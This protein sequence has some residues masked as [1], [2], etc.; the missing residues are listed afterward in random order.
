MPPSY[1]ITI[2]RFTPSPSSQMNTSYTQAKSKSKSSG[3]PASA[4][5]DCITFLQTLASSLPLH[6]DGI[7]TLSTALAKNTE[8]SNALS[9]SKAALDTATAQHEA[10]LRTVQTANEAAIR[11]R[12]VKLRENEV[13]LKLLRGGLKR[14]ILEQDSREADLVAKVSDAEAA[15]KKRVAEVEA[16]G[17]RRVAKMEV[18]VERARREVDEVKRA[19]Q[20]S[21]GRERAAAAR[22]Q[23]LQDSINGLN[24]VVR[25]KEAEVL[26]VV[27]REKERERELGVVSVDVESFGAGLAG[28]ADRMQALVQEHI[29]DRGLPADP[30][31]LTQRQEHTYPDLRNALAQSRFLLPPEHPHASEFPVLLSNSPAG[32]ASLSARTQNLIGAALCSHIFRTLPLP[33][34]VSQQPSEIERYATTISA[35]LPQSQA[36]LWRSLAF[37]ALESASGDRK[38]V[39]AVGAGVASVVAP[40]FADDTTAGAAF[41]DALHV[42]LD[43]A[44]AAWRGAC[45][46]PRAITALWPAT[47]EECAP[48]V[49]FAM[50]ALT[51]EVE[52]EGTVAG[53]DTVL[54]V[55]P[56]VLEEGRERAVF[57]GRAVA[58]NAPA[59]VAARCEVRRIMKRL[60]AKERE[61]KGGSV[62]RYS[63]SSGTGSLGGTPRSPTF[64]KSGVAARAMGEA[65]K[66]GAFRTGAGDK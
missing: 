27:A 14:D 28:V 34:D 39:E 42:L 57:E 5:P 58:V 32:R 48:D 54:P 59:A 9:A 36:A 11:D 60:F 29:Y 21:E 23:E 35:A 50:P 33:A 7:R 16:A 12:E 2:D 22:V 13:A 63:V 37:T 1:T 6:T 38:L 8:L 45:H 66:N 43:A 17:K 46:H 62:R 10:R 31:G 53:C 55:F 19:L 47:E 65:A 15:A 4:I 52:M 51:E 3:P 40:L 25:G 30:T 56:V 44:V 49:E 64:P 24:V 20:A 18:E 26:T 41:R 61:R